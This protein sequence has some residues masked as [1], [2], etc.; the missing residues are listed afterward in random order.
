[1]QTNECYTKSKSLLEFKEKECEDLKQ[2]LLAFEKSLNESK[3]VHNN[4]PLES[5]K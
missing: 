5:L 4:S 2:K 3:S 1:M